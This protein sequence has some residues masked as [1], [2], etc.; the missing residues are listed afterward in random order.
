MF[1]CACACVHSHILTKLARSL[2]TPRHTT[3]LL[4][5]S[6]MKIPSTLNVRQEKSK[7][8]GRYVQIREEDSGS[9]ERGMIDLCCMIRMIREDEGLD[10]VSSRQMCSHELLVCTISCCLTLSCYLLLISTVRSPSL[11]PLSSFLILILHLHLHL[12]LHL[13]ILKSIQ[14]G[15]L[16]PLL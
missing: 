5:A 16:V 8:A 1:P 6:T 11:L 4:V 12:H 3:P 15:C 10:L 2:L 9:M 14:E 7:D 13:S